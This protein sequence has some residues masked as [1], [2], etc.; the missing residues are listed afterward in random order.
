MDTNIKDYQHEFWIIVFTIECS[1][2]F[3]ALFIST[4]IIIDSFKQSKSYSCKLLI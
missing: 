1:A 2:N 4:L 3:F